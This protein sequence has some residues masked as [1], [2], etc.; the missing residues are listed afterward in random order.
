[1]EEEGNVGRVQLIL[2]DLEKNVEG[3]G[4]VHGLATKREDI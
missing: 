4:I 1:V 3:L 2:G